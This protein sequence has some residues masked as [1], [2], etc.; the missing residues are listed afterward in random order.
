MMLIMFEIMLF[1]IPFLTIYA[2]HVYSTDAPKLRGAPP[3]DIVSPLGGCELLIWGT[4]LFWKKYG[5]K[6]YFGRHFD[7]L[8]YEAKMYINLEKYV[9]H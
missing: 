5:R 7:W 4:Y 6:V 9:T 1:L 8:K 3:R 2:V